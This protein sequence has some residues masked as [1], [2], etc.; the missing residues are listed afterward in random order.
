MESPNRHSDH[1]H[2]RRRRKRKRSTVVQL[3]TA[4]SSDADSSDTSVDTSDGDGVINCCPETVS[5]TAF[6]GTKTMPTPGASIPLFWRPSFGT[7]MSG[8][9]TVLAR[10]ARA[11]Q[12]SDSGVVSLKALRAENLE[13]EGFSTVR[14]RR[15]QVDAS[16]PTTKPRGLEHLD[17]ESLVHLHKQLEVERKRGPG[18]LVIHG[19]LSGLAATMVVDTGA[20]VSCLSTK[21]WVEIH[22]THPGWT[23][24]PSSER[25]RTVSGDQAK[26]IGALV[27]EVELDSG[28]YAHRFLVMDMLEDVILGLDFIQK[29]DLAWD[30]A[31]GRL[32][33]H[34]REVRVTRRYNVGDGK[35]RRLRLCERTVLSAQSQILVEAHV[36]DR[37][38]GELPDWGVTSAL[39]EPVR[40]HGVTTARALVDPSME[41]IP[42]LV[43]NPGATQVVLPKRFPIA[44]MVPAG[45]V[46][47]E[48]L[49]IETGA[50]REQRAPS[51]PC[52]EQSESAMT[53]LTDLRQTKP[54]ELRHVNKAS[55]WCGD[56]P[57]APTVQRGERVE[58]ATSGTG[59]APPVLTELTVRCTQTASGQSPDCVWF[60]ESDVGVAEGHHGDEKPSD[61]SSAS[62]SDDSIGDARVFELMEEVAS[63]IPG[64]SISGDSDTDPE[65]SNQALGPVPEMQEEDKPPGYPYCFTKRKRWSDLEDTTEPESDAE[66]KPV[67][68]GGE[69]QVPEHLRKLYQ[70]SASSLDEDG[71]KK[72][73][74]F[75]NKNADV[76]AKSSEDLGR[77]NL[78]KH[79]IDTGDHAPVK[80]PPR[81]VPMHKKHIV[82]EELDKMLAKGVVEEC[83]GPWSSP[84]VLVTKK[85]NTSR[86]CIDYRRLNSL[87]KKDAY[88]LPRIEEN[89]DALEGATRFS[90]LDL[91]SGFW[92]VEVEPED[93]DKT[94]FTIGGGGLYR[95][96]TM[97]FGLC[98]APA[99]FERLMERVLRGLQ[100]K[101][102]V[103]YIDDVVVYSATV[104]EHFDRLNLVL[105]RFRG[106]GLR[107]KPSKCCLLAER[108][109]FLGHIVSAKGVEVDPGKIARVK[110]WPEPR[111]LREV[112]SF[113]GLCAY[114][115]RYVPNFSTICKPLFLLTKKGEPFVWGPA[116]KSAMSRMKELL[117]QAPILGYPREEGMFILDTDACNFGI[118]AV[119]SQVQDGEERVISYASKTLSKAQ[120]RYCVTRL[121]LLAI[122]TFVSQF[123]HY[124]W[125]RTFLVRTDHAALYWLLRKKDP[126]G[127]MARWV[128][129]LQVYHMDIEHR[130]GLKHGNADALSRCLEGC[131]DMDALEIPVG[132]TCSLQELQNR[133]RALPV[134]YFSRTV[135]TVREKV[136]RIGSVASET[137]GLV[138][139]TNSKLVEGWQPLSQ[140][141]CDHVVSTSSELVE[142]CE[143]LDK[144]PKGGKLVSDKR[145]RRKR[146]RKASSVKVAVTMDSDGQ[147]QTV[148]QQLESADGAIDSVN[149]TVNEGRT[150]KVQAAGV[151]YPPK[152]KPGN[153]VTPEEMVA[154]QQQEQYLKDRPPA[155]WDPPALARLQELDPSVKRVREWVKGKRPPEWNEI[156][157]E[158]SVVKAWLARYEQLFLSENG[159]LYLRWEAERPK[160]PPTYRVVATVSMFAPILTELHNSKTA[161]HL[162][163]KKTIARLK[164]SPFYWPGM[165]AFA[166]RWVDRCDVC[167]ARKLPKFSKKGPLQNYH[168]GSTMDRVS[169][170]LLG[171]FPR[172][173]RGNT[174]ILTVTDHF[175]R[176][177]ECFPL[178]QG[179]ATNVARCV[180]DFIC[181]LGMPLEIHSDMGK[182]VDG[183]LLHEICDIL[184]V[185]KTHTTAYTPWA[186]GYSERENAVIKAM[187]AAFVN[188]RQ[189]N[190][191]E[192]LAPLMLAYRSSVH[193]ILGEAPSTMMLG[194]RLRLPLDA[195]VGQPPEAEYREMQAAEYA[196]ELADSMACAHEVVSAQL[197]AKYDYQKKMYDRHVRAENFYEGQAVWL[198]EFPGRKGVARSLLPNY[199]GPWIIMK[200]LSQV[201]YRIQKTRHGRSQVVHV[202]RLKRYCGQI[203]CPWQL[204]YWRPAATVAEKP[205]M[206][207]D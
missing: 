63:D 109:E 11:Q 23:L 136:P 31:R 97:P 43:M 155:D 175:T 96:V 153:A 59:N 185:R 117:T 68:V 79:K 21:L 141:E 67:S 186:N 58:D 165:A 29:Y 154:F 45:M 164:A 203:T 54:T 176:W 183:A 122:L 48:S 166:R 98:N 40:S 38:K 116:Q 28:Y 190:W 202:N 127:Q 15:V 144:D 129:K 56:P 140:S 120:T 105:D 115:R 17:L 91:I 93:R 149:P 30:R 55:S 137:P 89:L 160:D 182:S 26:V 167:A 74:G 163:Q 4:C 124:L 88:P 42:V 86:F 192:C 113:V 103:L 76:F 39:K 172:T 95:F 146:K 143:R 13:S 34:G 8:E 35:A 78:V 104:D 3:S 20:S 119:L 82:Q 173:S 156:A 49:G 60:G 130:P 159:V 50:E 12:S 69:D 62:D 158:N 199:S 162:G 14:C 198:R 51:A 84:I 37:G 179:S 33:L 112:R 7:G 191:D 118:G 107:L 41:R 145:K 123:H 5:E 134:R 65:P 71:R 188:R 100:W 24:M 207:P 125:G 201:N 99:T 128:T 52:V 151:G 193:R 194:R 142:G 53:E 121:E 66:A 101:I 152:P 126:E 2:R 178:R 87:T 6:A 57:V 206:T 106:A 108:V 73:V 200:R 148:L 25:V 150:V 131:R 204:E 81:R 205:P 72:L 80:Q 138:A 189:T 64:M 94:A 32:L 147:S 168:V 10:L 90:T 157:Q 110:D 36:Q 187:L 161:G 184:G 111:N 181:R 61:T 197:N 85:D 180:V 16:G 77:T 139:S 27:I 44:L 70:D 92:Q 102:A 46:G 1:D 9:D 75:L 22:R 114:Y 135:P 170:D 195:F 47:A 171:P 18:E 19:R 132:E 83:D 196:Q 169:I 177:V 174:V 133:A